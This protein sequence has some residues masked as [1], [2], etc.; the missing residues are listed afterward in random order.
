MEQEREQRLEP[1][2]VRSFNGDDPIQILSLFRQ[3]MSRM[4][5]QLLHLT[6]KDGSESVTSELEQIEEY[7]ERVE[8]YLL[9]ECFGRLAS[10]E[11]RTNNVVLEHLP[12]DIRFVPT[13]EGVTISDIP[14]W[15]IGHRSRKKLPPMYHRDRPMI[16]KIPMWQALVGHLKAS[17]LQSVLQ[18][19]NMLPDRPSD[20]AHMVFHFHTGHFQVR[21]L[22]HYEVAPIVNACVSNGLFASDHPSRLSLT[23]IWNKV[24]GEPRFDVHVRYVA[25]AAPLPLDLGML[26]GLDL[27]KSSKSKG[28]IQR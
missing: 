3:T 15:M 21:D 19:N 8:T 27:Q 20:Y 11:W 13:S 22:D 23:M 26:L 16:R 6:T 28:E 18:E 14:L 1:P 24:T 7:Q 2:E 17:Y 4:N 25:C 10:Y 12:S 9:E 5:E